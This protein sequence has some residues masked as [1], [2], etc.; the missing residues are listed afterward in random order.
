MW[1]LAGVGQGQAE[2]IYAGRT[3]ARGAL[4]LRLTAVGARNRL[5]GLQDMEVAAKADFFAVELKQDRV[6][7]ATQRARLSLEGTTNWNLTSQSRLTPRVEAGARWDRGT[8]AATGAGAEV[9]GGLYYAHQ[10]Y[11]LEVE[12]RGSRLLAH[13]GDVSEHRIGLQATLNY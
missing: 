1:G 12:V 13:A 4:D 10:G 11:G 5:L 3:E 9:G 2:L 6:L 8:S 7:A